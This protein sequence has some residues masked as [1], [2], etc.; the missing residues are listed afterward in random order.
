MMSDWPN[1]Q[2]LCLVLAGLAL[3]I[4]GLAACIARYPEMPAERDGFLDQ[5]ETHR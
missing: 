3:F 5:Q 2:G 4:V 1:I